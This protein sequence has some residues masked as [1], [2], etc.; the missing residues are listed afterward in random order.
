MKDFFDDIYEMLQLEQRFSERILDMLKEVGRK[1]ESL[2][3][4]SHIRTTEAI[5]H[6]HC[7]KTLFV[8]ESNISIC[9][10]YTRF[11]VDEDFPNCTFLS[12]QGGRFYFA[13]REIHA[14]EPLSIQLFNKTIES[15]H[16]SLHIFNSCSKK[17]L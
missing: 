17:G 14:T 6:S 13:T 16:S 12:L 3:D 2:G 1:T 10:E 11:Q 9:P 8:N 5:F 4:I 15:N 7:F